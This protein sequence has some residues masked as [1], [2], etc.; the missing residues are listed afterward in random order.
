MIQNRKT[1]KAKLQMLYNQGILNKLQFFNNLKQI[2]EK[3][4]SELKKLKRKSLSHIDGVQILE[5][6]SKIVQLNKNI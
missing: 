6:S 1:S 2:D 4:I 5:D 3:L